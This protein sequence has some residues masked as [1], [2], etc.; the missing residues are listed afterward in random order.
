MAMPPYLARRQQHRIGKSG[1]KS[2]DRLSKTLG[3]R[4]RPASGAMDGA[5]GDIGVG[6]FL[7]E[8]KST[9]SLS[10]SLKLD[11]LV[12]IAQEARAEHKEPALTVSFVRPDGMPVKDGEW[13]LVPMAR[14][15]ELVE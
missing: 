9:T 8:A 5:K 12:K 13:V 3:G 2:E 1:R 6:Q 14:W 11:W 4:S 15:R 10:M 7:I